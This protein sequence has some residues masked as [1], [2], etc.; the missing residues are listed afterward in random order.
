MGIDRETFYGHPAIGVAA[1]AFCYPGT[2][3][4]GG[5]HPPPARCATLWRSRLLE[6]LPKVELT[7]LLAGRPRCGPWVEGPKA[8]WTAPCAPGQTICP[9][10]WVMPHPSWRNSGWLA[11]N[12][13]FEAEVTPYLRRRVRDLLAA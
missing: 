1:M 2:A 13:W 11:H 5:D 8:R 9:P 7:L 3:A 4:G 10:S 12:P 6:S